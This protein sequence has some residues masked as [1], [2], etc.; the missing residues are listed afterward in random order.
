MWRGFTFPTV[1]FKPLFMDL[2]DRERERSLE[3]VCKMRPTQ[4]CGSHTAWPS[5]KPRQL[6][7][8]HGQGNQHGTAVE[9]SNM[10]PVAQSKQRLRERLRELAVSEGS[11]LC[12]WPL[13]ESMEILHTDWSTKLTT[14]LSHWSSKPILFH[15]TCLLFLSDFYKFTLHISLLI[16][17][18][19]SG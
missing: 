19:W 8:S 17:T 9:Q 10:A 1:V 14:Q 7:P 6:K 16:V 12:K 13:T 4:E 3:V 18:F 2:R 15:S 11:R 5:I